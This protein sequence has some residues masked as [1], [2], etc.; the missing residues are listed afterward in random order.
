MNKLV[1][2][3]VEIH[4]T[5]SVEQPVMRSGE[6]QVAD[7]ILPALEE[8]QAATADVKAVTYTFTEL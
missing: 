3:R 7:F 6:S 4:V 5:I 1:T 2:V 8:L